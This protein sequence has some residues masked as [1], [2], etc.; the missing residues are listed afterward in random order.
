[1]G[2]TLD[3]LERWLVQLFHHN[4]P[5][6]FVAFFWKAGVKHLAIFV[7]VSRRAF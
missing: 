7:S 2:E 6:G 5:G 4:N 3:V 1:M